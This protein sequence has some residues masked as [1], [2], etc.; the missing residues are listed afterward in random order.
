MLPH[1]P[2]PPSLARITSKRT[3]SS[4][5][6]KDSHHEQASNASP[7]SASTPRTTRPNVA[8]R[9]ASAPLLPLI[10]P[11][12]FLANDDED[13]FFNAY[14]HRDSVTSMKDDPF[15]RNYQSPSSVSLARELRS[16]TYSQHH[17][18]DNDMGE[19]PRSTRKLSTDTF[20]AM[21]LPV[22]FPFPV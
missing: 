6:S 3:R 2:Y 18:R 20:N 9:T 16:A 14:N 13:D 17:S 22:R 8:S 5:A 4:N 12:K 7:T 10:S 11:P 19:D 21:S 1:P 15:F